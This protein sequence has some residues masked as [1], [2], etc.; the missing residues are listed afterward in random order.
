P[1]EVEAVLRQ[2][3]AIVEA[4]VVG[5]PNAEWGQQV[6]AAVMLHPATNVTPEALIAFCRTLLA[7]YKTP[8]QLRI[9]DA[10]PLTASGKI[11]RRAVSALWA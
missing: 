3:P 4:C 2:H 6:V 8:R 11:E 1:A 7:G 10:L 9:V 5:I